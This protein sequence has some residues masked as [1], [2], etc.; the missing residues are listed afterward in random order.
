MISKKDGDLISKYIPK[1][2]VAISFEFIWVSY[3]FLK[4]LN[5]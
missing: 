4:S 2:N 3:F 1:N 5:P